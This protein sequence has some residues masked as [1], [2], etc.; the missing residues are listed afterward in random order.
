MG[1]R[2]HESEPRARPRPRGAGLVPTLAVFVVCLVVL[3]ANGRPVGDPD[4]SGLAGWL[5]RAAS[6]LAGSVIQ[7]DVTGRLI[8]G[9]VLSDRKSTRLNSSHQKIS[10]AVF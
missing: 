10:Y 3:L 8:V 4:P 9:K 5:W 6:L 7:L 2:V 1:V